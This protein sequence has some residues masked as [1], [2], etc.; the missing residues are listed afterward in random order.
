MSGPNSLPDSFLR[1]AKA[2][3]LL[4]FVAYLVAIPCLGPGALFVPIVVIQA[5]IGIISYFDPS[6]T[7]AFSSQSPGNHD[8]LTILIH[9]CFWLL[10][11]VGLSVRNM[12]SIPWLRTIWYTLVIMLIMSVSGCAMHLG[13]DLRNSF[14]WH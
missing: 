6:V 9:T 7:R 11:W 2:W 1:T 8:E 14:N 4:P 5:P 3:V 10:L 13:P 12:L